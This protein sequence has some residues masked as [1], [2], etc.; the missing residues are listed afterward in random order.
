MHV[1]MNRGGMSVA[2]SARKKGDVVEVDDKVGEKLVADGHAREAT[3]ADKKRAAKAEADAAGV[4][5]S[6]VPEGKKPTA[7]DSRDL[8]GK[9]SAATHAPEG[10]EKGSDLEVAT[11]G[12]GGTDD[13]GEAGSAKAAKAEKVAT[14]QAA[15]KGG[16]DA[17]T[18]HSK[19]AGKKASA[20]RK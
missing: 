16:T 4:T 13:A 2:G 11:K 10:A 7:G 20:K 3:A 12:D 1:T 14:E 15:E 17:P 8:S 5:E 6:E 18:A 9:H 19:P